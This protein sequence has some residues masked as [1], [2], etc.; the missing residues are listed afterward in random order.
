MNVR[1]PEAF[2]YG[3][4]EPDVEFPSPSVITSFFHR[5]LCK[6]ISGRHPFLSPE[7]QS[8][9]RGHYPLL[10][11]PNLYPPEMIERVYVNRRTPAAKII[12]EDESPVVFD[13]GCGYGSESFLFASLGAKVLAVDICEEKIQIAEKRQ[14]FYEEIMGKPLDI[15]FAVADLDEYTAD[16]LNLSVTWLASVLA[17]VRDQDKFLA[18]IHQATRLGGQVMITD[19]NL[20]N[21]LFLIKEWCRRQQAKNECFEF[22]LHSDFWA[23]LKRNGRIGARYFPGHNGRPFDDVQFFSAMTLSKLLSNVGFV[24]RS[25]F[26]SGFIPPYLWQLGLGSLENLFSRLSLLRWFGYFYLVAGMKQ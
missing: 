18:K 26:S 20:L 22:A 4:S 15:T 16:T 11:A 21:P 19:M 6:E 25:V 12:L 1:L 17:A 14:R 3:N 10:L 7:E 8:K 9:L 13:G 23:M 24:P 5:L 2:R